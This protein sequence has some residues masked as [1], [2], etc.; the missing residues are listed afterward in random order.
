MNTEGWKTGRDREEKMLRETKFARRSLPKQQ[1][2][3]ASILSGTL[4][5]RSPVPAFQMDSFDNKLIVDRIS[6]VAL[7]FRL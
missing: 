1:L 7:C 2:L 6:G 4:F 3:D 5:L